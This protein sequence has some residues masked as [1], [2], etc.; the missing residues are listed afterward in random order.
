MWKYIVQK[1]GK[2]IALLLAAIFVVFVILEQAPG[3]PAKVILG[4]PVIYLYP[5]EVTDVSVRL[6][7]A[8]EMI[9]T[10]PA[11]RDGWQVTAH[12]DGTLIDREGK[13][14]S[15]L[16]WEAESAAD[17]DM[18]RGFCIPG[19]DTASFLEESLTALGLNV[20]ERNEFIIYW[21]PR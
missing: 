5:E 1:I 17:F 6:D 10:Y 16:F 20:R 8:G 19:A 18:T 4:K 7:V 2:Y 11:Y 15:C 9:C 13:T 14:Y 21:L 12:P 3:D